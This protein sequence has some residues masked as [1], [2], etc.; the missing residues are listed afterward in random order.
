MDGASRG[1]HNRTR[2]GCGRIL[3]SSRLL[4]S[5]AGCIRGPRLRDESGSG[6]RGGQNRLRRADVLLLLGGLPGEIPGKSWQIHRAAGVSGRTAPALC[7]A[8]FFAAFPGPLRPL[9]AAVDYRP[10]QSR[11]S[12]Q[13]KKHVQSADAHRKQVI[14]QKHAGYPPLQVNGGKSNATA[15]VRYMTQP[16]RP[17]GP[18]G[19]IRVDRRRRTRGPGP[20]RS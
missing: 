10:N 1:S 14:A 18:V 20:P 8:D 12:P 7:V 16:V 11:K 19:T 4:G 2:R 17:A 6:A 5:L 15:S 9:P 13:Q 3:R